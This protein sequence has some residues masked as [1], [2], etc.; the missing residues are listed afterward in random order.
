MSQVIDFD[1]PTPL[2]SSADCHFLGHRAVPHVSRI[3]TAAFT[4]EP[5]RRTAVFERRDESPFASASNDH[6]PQVSPTPM[7]TARLGAYVSSRRARWQ[8][9]QNSSISFSHFV[10]D[11]KATW[12]GDHS[13]SWWSSSILSCQLCDPSHRSVETVQRQ[14][15]GTDR[16]LS[17][18]SFDCEY[19]CPLYHS[20]LSASIVVA[21]MGA[22]CILSLR[23]HLV[24][25]QLMG[26]Q[27][28]SNRCSSSTLGRYK[29]VCDP[30]ALDPDRR[31]I[32]RGAVCRASTMV[33]ELLTG[34]S[35]SRTQTRCV[36]F[37][38]S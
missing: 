19:K 8:R 34:C 1:H 36:C 7:K 35:R 25:Q 15:R 13:S 2:I 3:V 4:W 17:A 32:E 14:R 6:R 11:L 20:A 38:F 12:L 27:D 33:L 28:R 18:G 22:S 9:L 29:L 24:L 31:C 23:N 21:F 16:T 10:Y 5:C 37:C 26:A 30:A